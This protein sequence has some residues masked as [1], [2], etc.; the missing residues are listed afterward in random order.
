MFF[1]SS[2]R[3]ILFNSIY[4]KFN[5]L[6]N[7]K[8]KSFNYQKIIIFTIGPI[9][10][11]SLL[12][13]KYKA[14]TFY[15]L[16]GLGRIFSSE[17]F[18]NNLIRIFTIRIYKYLF[19]RCKLVFVL[20]SYDFLFLIENRICSI[21]KIKV[22]PGTG[23]NYIQIEKAIDKKTKK[24]IVKIDKKYFRPTEVNFLYGDSTKAKKI[25]KWSPKNNIDDLIKKM[26]DFE[27]D[28]YC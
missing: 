19:K 1:L 27:L 10:I 13:Q 24:T 25:L 11:S 23:L 26:C 20:N 3:N 6:L 8:I 17:K 5:S 9:L 22:L 7:F 4:Y 28:Q 14:N 16:E 2:F 21:E 18:L 12:P 15:V